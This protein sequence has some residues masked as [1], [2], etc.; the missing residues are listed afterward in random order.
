MTHEAVDKS[1]CLPFPE[2]CP[3]PTGTPV[4][5]EMEC[6][7]AITGIRALR[8]RNPMRILFTSC[9]GTGH[10]NPLFRYAE[11]IRKRG[12]QVRFAST[13]PARVAVEKAGFEFVPVP[14]ATGAE[15]DKV[16]ADLDAAT[17]EEALIIGTRDLFGGILAKAALPGISDVIRDWAPDLIVRESSE[18]AGL[19]AAQKLGVKSVRVSVMAPQFYERYLDVAHSAIDLLRQGVDMK[20][21]HG[22]ALLAEPVFCAF[23]ESMDRDEVQRPKVFR[24][25]Q[26]SSRAAGASDP[27]PRWAP[28]NGEPLIYMTFGTVSG[29]S[30]RVQAT[31]RRALE[32]VGTLPVRALLTTGPVMRADLLGT[33]PDNVFVE[34]FVPQDE[35]LP[36]SSA[37]VN[38]GGSGTLLGTLAAGLPQVVIPMFAD[39]PHNARSL[40]ASGAGI[41]V[42]DT[43]TATLRSAIERVLVDKDIQAKA[44]QV[45]AEIAAMPDIEAAADELLALATAYWPDRSR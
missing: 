32:A 43:D 8:K 44:R 30:E 37:V 38:H 42:F 34:T 16:F 17:G 39:Q 25:G 35:V 41:A 9:S 7:Y 24:V 12:H 23:P 29:R 36:H 4:R 31:Y 2:C 5:L 3:P 11:A 14:S 21:D 33:I 1:R 40:Q 10:I 45:A 13:E 18:Y 15:R 28:Q 6:L 26:R 22:A 19:I 27:L 20:P